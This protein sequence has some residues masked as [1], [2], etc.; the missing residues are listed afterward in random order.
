MPNCT[1]FSKWCCTRGDKSKQE[2]KHFHLPWAAFAPPTSCLYLLPMGENLL[3]LSGL[4]H[5][6]AIVT[7]DR[8]GGTFWAVVTWEQG[9]TA[10][11]S[12]A[13]D[14]VT[15]NSQPSRSSL[16]SV[17]QQKKVTCSHPCYTQTLATSRCCSGT[18]ALRVQ[19]IMGRILGKK[20]LLCSWE[21]EAL[22]QGNQLWQVAATMVWHK[23]TLSRAS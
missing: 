18:Q 22:A 16:S 9:I 13:H 4:K 21:E 6:C 11:S 14:G 10:H 2:Q 23:V 5:P 3:I 7:K 17:L 12:A 8:Q 19:I 15:L 20:E 1:S